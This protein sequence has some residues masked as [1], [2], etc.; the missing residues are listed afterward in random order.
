MM[1]M[2]MLSISKCAGKPCGINGGS[3]ANGTHVTVDLRAVSCRAG[4]E[5][6]I[7]YGCWSNEVFFMF[8]GFVPQ[9]NPWDSVGI[10]RDLSEMI[11]YH[12]RIEVSHRKSPRTLPS[13]D[14]VSCVC[15]R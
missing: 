12:D 1:W 11:A 5:V 14:D 13:V 9:D 3:D 7:S 10:F 15:M 2:V 6:T 4:E 8:F